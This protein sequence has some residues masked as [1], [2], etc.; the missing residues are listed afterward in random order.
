MS[1]DVE[2]RTKGAWEC[3]KCSEGA[4]GRTEGAGASLTFTPVEHKLRYALR[5]PAAV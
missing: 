5:A 2:G 4:L 3:N 1:T